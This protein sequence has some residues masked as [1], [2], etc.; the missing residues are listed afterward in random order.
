VKGY[1]VDATCGGC[2]FKWMTSIAQKKENLK[3]KSTYSAKWTSHVISDYAYG[4]SVNSFENL[5]K[6]LE[7]CSEYPLWTPPYTTKYAADC[8]NSPIPVKGK[9]PPP[10]VVTGF[11]VG[12]EKDTFSLQ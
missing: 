2:M 9:L 5:T 12:G 7:Y 11:A 4:G 1:V 6:G 3:D 10:I 8:K